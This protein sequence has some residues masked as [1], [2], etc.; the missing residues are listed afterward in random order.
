VEVPRVTWKELSSKADAESSTEIQQRVSLAR[1]R[2]RERFKSA[3]ADLYS[4]SLM[5]NKEIE[6]FAPLDSPSM[7][8]LHQAIDRMSLSARAYHRIRKIARTI[9]DLEVTEEIQL[10]HVIE[11]V[12]YRSLDRVKDIAA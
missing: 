6:R 7:D 4:N 12:Q 10:S 8:V 2:Q 3:R 9:A 1:R 5:S 11:A